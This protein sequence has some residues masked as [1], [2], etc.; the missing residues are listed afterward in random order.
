MAIVDSVIDS[1]RNGDEDFELTDEG[2]INKYIGLLIEYIHDSSLEMS[3][4]LLVLHII[5]SLSLDENKTRVSNTPVGNP[6]LNR[7]LDGCPRKHKWL[8][9]GAAGMLRY[10][11]NNVRPEIHMAVHQTVRYP[12][13]PMRSHELDIMRIGQYMVY[14]PDCGVIYTIDKTKEL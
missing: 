12:M 14:N 3:Q 7:D 5:A 11:A 9:Q 8:Y 6:L 1:L 4:P 13:N 2:S 10:L